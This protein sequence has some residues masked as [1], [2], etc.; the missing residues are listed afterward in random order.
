MPCIFSPISQTP[1]KQLQNQH[2]NVKFFFS[3]NAKWQA[4][5][6]SVSHIVCLF[7]PTRCVSSCVCT[8]GTSPPTG[9]SF[10]SCWLLSLSQ[11]NSSCSD[12][13][14][15]FHEA[16]SESRWALETQTQVF[17]FLVLYINIM[18]LQNWAT[19]SPHLM[20]RVLLRRSFQRWLMLSKRLWSTEPSSESL[21]EVTILCPL[22]SRE[23]YSSVWLSISAW[24]SW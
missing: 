18:I 2:Q 15:L 21:S 16:I 11:F 14:S 10:S 17:L 19:A 3:K 1:L 8:A 23:W 4:V 7:P 9:G 22:S 13:W 12:I 24:R 6:L 20:L 5:C